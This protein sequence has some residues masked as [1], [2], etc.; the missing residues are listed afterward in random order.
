[1]NI[2]RFQYCKYFNLPG[3]RSFAD[4]VKLRNLRWINYPRWPR[5]VQYN[6]KYPY[7]WKRKVGRS[8]SGMMWQRSRGW[9]DDIA[10]LQDGRWIKVKKCRQPLQGGRDKEMFFV[11]FCFVLFSPR[12]SRRN[13]SWRNICSLFWGDAPVVYGIS[14]ARDQIWEASATYTTA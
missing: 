3:K 12:A 14:Q 8:L 10:G 2:L 7:R 1:M 6:H 5:W 11:L 9:I 4:V 13:M